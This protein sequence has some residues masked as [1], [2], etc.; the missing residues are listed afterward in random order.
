[1]QNIIVMARTTT[2]PKPTTVAVRLTER[3]A[4]LL[5]KMASAAGTSKGAVIRSLIRAAAART[6]SRRN[7]SSPA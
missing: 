5:Q 4:V 2:E 3:D 6:R 7:T 1:M